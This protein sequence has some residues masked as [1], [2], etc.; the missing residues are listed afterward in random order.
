MSALLSI[1]KYLILI[2]ILQSIM[3]AYGTMIYNL[4][5]PILPETITGKIE[6]SVILNSLF[7]TGKP[8]YSSLIGLAFY[9]SFYIIAFKLFR[10][11]N[12]LTKLLFGSLMIMLIGGGMTLIKNQLIATICG[13]IPLL[14]ALLLL[15]FNRKG[16]NK[17]PSTHNTKFEKKNKQAES[18]IFK[19]SYGNIQLENPFRGIYIQGGAGSGKSVSVFEPIIAQISEQ[20]Y[21]GLLYD[22]KS[23]ELTNKVLEAYQRNTNIRSFVVDFKNPYASDRVNPIEPLYLVKSAYAL[24]YATTLI[25]N[26]LP[27]TIKERDFFSDN[28]RMVLSGVIWF[29]RNS[30]SH[31]CT[32]PHVISL[33]LHTDI[34]K[35]IN[36]ISEDYEAGGF[37]SSLKQAI[38]RGAE[39]Q[40][41]GVAS[42]LQNALSQL[43]TKDI[44]WILSGN[45][46][47][48]HLNNPNN[49]KF[50]CLGND[51]TLSSTYAPVISLIISVALRLMNQPLQEKSIVLL[52][53]APTIYIPNIEQLPA[54]AR[55]NKVATIFGV[56]DYSQLVDKYGQEKAQV[57]LSNLG[58]QFYGRT[59]NAKTADMIKNLFGKHDRTY[60]TA[61]RGSGTSGEFIHLSSNT[62]KGMNESIQ[63]RD[64]VKVS[65][66]TNL[67]PGQFY[68]IIAEGSPKEF[69]NAQL[70]PSEIKSSYQRE[71][72]ATDQEMAENYER[73]V[74]EAKSIIN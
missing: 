33:L 38:D 36:I 64:R 17:N 60:Q 42:T 14:V 16:K 74:L 65:D 3:V 43:N 50:L 37:V 35:L 29:L 34:D 40:A 32:L 18:F 47:D 30:Y 41:A 56:Q 24:E 61:S 26:L 68:G 7:K 8:W 58:N 46:F 70:M 11:R 67:G 51:S 66:I 62:N 22:F 53:E 69:L 27:Q 25:N 21:T 71:N 72:K 19:T 45:N 23:P 6:S 12:F 55:S 48:L 59:V 2:I 54:T 31:Y 49:P 1:I 5:Y 28:A 63:E 20:G 57:I 4:A 52:D 9:T 15:I 13:F 44:F 73:I 39:R 10:D